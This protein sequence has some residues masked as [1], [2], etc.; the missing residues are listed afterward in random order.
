[1]TRIQV[2]ENYQENKKNNLESLLSEFN[3]KVDWTWIGD[4]SRRKVTFQIDGKNRLGFFANRSHDLIEIDCDPLAEEK[5]STLIPTLK[6]FLQKQEQNFFTQLTIT[7]FDNGLDL[8]LHGKKALT[9]SQEQKLMNFAKE[10]DFNISYRKG[11]DD[12]APIFQARPNQIFYDDFKIN[13]TSDIFIQATKS[14]LNRIV[15]IIRSNIKSGMK[16]ADIYAGYGAYSFAIYDLAK[17]VTAF[18]GDKK[19]ADLISKNASANGLAQKIKSQ[20]RDLFS[21][22]LDKTDL[23]DFDLVI[24]NP[25]RNGASP[26]AIEIAKSN[27]KNVIYVSCNPQSF[28]RDAKILIDSGFKIT[29]LNAIDQ[30][31]STEHLELVAIFQK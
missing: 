14:G 22:P 11:N 31:Y 6:S 26:Q 4:A 8:V 2:P 13:L 27:L 20:H 21:I 1:M 9:F 16:V 24:I 17:S 30:F 15:E 19:M 18:E 3:C 12:T 7:L 10:H 23:K 5:I 28:K 25:P 29:S